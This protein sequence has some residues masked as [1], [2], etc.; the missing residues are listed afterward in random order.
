M[1]EQPI[2]ASISIRLTM[3]QARMLFAR[4]CECRPLDLTRDEEDHATIHD[5]DTGIL[6]DIQV[7]CRIRTADEDTFRKAHNYC[8]R[9]L[10]A[11]RNAHGGWDVP[12]EGT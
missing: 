12:E 1:I 9:L 11:T 5:C 6:H 7:A 4:H 3:D 10:R 2:L 8:E